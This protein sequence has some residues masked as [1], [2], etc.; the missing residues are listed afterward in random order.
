MVLLASLR[1]AAKTIGKNA[2]AYIQ[3]NHGLDLIGWKFWEVLHDAA[4][5]K[6]AADQG[7]GPRRLRD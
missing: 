2:A 6:T 3:A 7:E 1:E 5:N 4:R